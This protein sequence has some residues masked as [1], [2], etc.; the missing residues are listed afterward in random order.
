MQGDGGATAHQAGG[1]GHPQGK[2]ATPAPGVEVVARQVATQDG[3][4]G[5]LCSR[6]CQIC[7]NNILSR[8]PMVLGCIKTF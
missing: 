5:A 6:L 1:H 2:G 7:K 8:G 3:G 4:R